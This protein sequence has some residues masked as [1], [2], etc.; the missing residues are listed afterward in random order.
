MQQRGTQI[1]LIFREWDLDCAKPRGGGHAG[2]TNDNQKA[3]TP[4]MIS[5]Y[6]LSNVQVR[7]WHMGGTSDW[8]SLYSTSN[9]NYLCLASTKG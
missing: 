4:M 9:R 2:F 8:N 6:S 3:S 7:Y 1:V 5:E